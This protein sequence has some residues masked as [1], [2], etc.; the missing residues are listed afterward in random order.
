[1]GGFGKRYERGGE[2]VPFCP[3]SCCVAMKLTVGDLDD[4]IVDQREI[5]CVGDQQSQVGQ[6]IEPPRVA[7]SSTVKRCE[8]TL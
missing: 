7:F 2:F 5:L 3:G 1:M 6:A 8:G 4:V